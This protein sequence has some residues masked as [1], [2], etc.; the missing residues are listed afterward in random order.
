IAVLFIYMGMSI[1]THVLSRFFTRQFERRADEY[2]I[3][4]TGDPQ[5]FRSAMTRI[6]DFRKVGK[7]SQVRVFDSHPP[8]GQ[9]IAMADR[10][11]SKEA[12]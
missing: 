5:A 7:T 2:A 1:F 8:F 4:V 6:Y 10:M 3:R 12:A 11:T 9:R